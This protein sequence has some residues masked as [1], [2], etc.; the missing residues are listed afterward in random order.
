MTEKKKAKKKEHYVNNKEFLAAIT[1]FKEQVESA[2]SEG[3]ERPRVSNYIGD[4]IMK[5]AVHL[6]HKPN[7]S[8]YT[9]FNINKFR[10]KKIKWNSK[11][12]NSIW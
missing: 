6:S 11:P 9:F 7:F 8:N 3:L 1:I 12:S 5:I 2:K 10:M 4:C